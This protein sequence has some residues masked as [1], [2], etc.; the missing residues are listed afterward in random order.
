MD[1]AVGRYDRLGDIDD[2]AV[3][4]A[5]EGQITEPLGKSGRALN[6]DEEEYALLQLW[7]VIVPG[8]EI[9]QHI[10]PEQVVNLIN[11]PNN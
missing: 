10:L 7:L 1:F 11:E 6:I 4:Q 8:D 2:K 5:V 3:D 9:E